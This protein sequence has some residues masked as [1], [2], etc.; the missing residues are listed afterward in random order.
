MNERR[1][2]STLNILHIPG[3][4]SVQDFPS[5]QI[6]LISRKLVLLQ[7]GPASIMLLKFLPYYFPPLIILHK[8]LSSSDSS[9]T[10]PLGIPKNCHFMLT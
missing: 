2:N 10:L 7:N 3:K 8:I 9:F 6:L 4:I 1:S 5:K